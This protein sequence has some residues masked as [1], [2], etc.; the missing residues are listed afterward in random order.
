MFAHE[1]KMCAALLPDSRVVVP[2]ISMMQE[3][4]LTVSRLLKGRTLTATFTE[5]MAA[6]QSGGEGGGRR[7]LFLLKA[8]S[9]SHLQ[10]EGDCFTTTSMLGGVSTKVRGNKG[11]PLF[12]RGL[13][14]KKTHKGERKGRL[15]NRFIASFPQV[16]QCS[17]IATDKLGLRGGR[18]KIAPARRR[19]AGKREK[20]GVM[21][22][23][24]RYNASPP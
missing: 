17:G 24:P 13:G 23:S 14:R 6:K 18:K 21:I 5:D 3:Q 12:L 19:E 4:S 10:W 9:R 8:T 20:A 2:F 16:L 15:I 22:A 11:A 7:S 1:K